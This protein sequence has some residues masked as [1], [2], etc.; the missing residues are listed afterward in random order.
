MQSA[1]NP[2]LGLEKTDELI[3]IYGRVEYVKKNL[4]NIT[5][6]ITNDVF[7]VNLEK[8]K[9]PFSGYKDRSYESMKKEFDNFV[10]TGILKPYGNGVYENQ[11][12]VK[13]HLIEILQKRS[14]GKKNK[15]G[16]V[17]KN[18]ENARVIIDKLKEIG[19]KLP[20]KG[21]D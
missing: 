1:V 18:S 12:G 2:L 7:I 13:I 21:V 16:G 14:D 10:N 11:H 15:H 8:D 19:S 9:N 20:I 17:L 6:N 5:K 4:P 3:S